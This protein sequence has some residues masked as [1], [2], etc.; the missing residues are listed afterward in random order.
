M[1]PPIILKTIL[2][3]LFLFVIFGTIIFIIFVGIFI[4]NSEGSIP[5]RV[6]DNLIASLNAEAYTV[7]GFVLLSRILFIYTV[8]KFKY[9]VR[10]FFKG[11]FLNVEQVKLTRIIGQL[12]IIVALLDTVPGVIYQTFFEQSPR[13]VDYGLASADS[14]WF[15]IAIGL[16]FLFL[17]KIFENARIMKEENELTV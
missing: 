16:F 9:L 8:Y 4:F 10:L 11:K 12:I 7:L 5:F 2:D 13:R 1:K 6:N 3:I 14:F 17:S 15:I